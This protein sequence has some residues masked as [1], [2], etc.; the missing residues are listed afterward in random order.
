MPQSRQNRA[1]P[2][3]V[4][5]R[6]GPKHWLT[7]TRK[8]SILGAA[9]TAPAAIF[10]VLVIGYPLVYLFRLSL[11]KVTWL[12][13]EILLSW[14]G[15]TNYSQVLHDALFWAAFRHTLLI[16]VVS[17]SASL[18]LGLA[19]AI[20][21]DHISRGRIL[22]QTALL[23]PWVIA[24][25]LSSAM[26]KWLYNDQFGIINYVLTSLHLVKQPILWL[27]D[28]KIAI[29]SIILADFWQY[30]PFVMILLF[31]GLQ[32]IPQQLYEAA[33]I[34][35]ANSFQLLRHIS[36]PNLKPVLLF[37]ILIRTVFTLRI[38]DF[39]YT[40][41]RGGPAG[42]TQVLATLLYNSAFSFM[43]YGYAAAVAV[44]LL[45]ITIIASSG[46]LA[47]FRGDSA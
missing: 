45:I 13:G 23:L 46:I 6:L 32:A 40:L 34:D 33:R 20:A 5:Q 19:L 10:L 41:T 11:S 47:L 29:F 12:P 3:S 22:M 15:L 18:L 37:V 26:W 17:V 28:P 42:S 25:A 38:F 14:T 1:E 7:I 24:P 4:K 36:L 43:K 8:D 16:L 35:G 21:L 27:A 9:L 44:I 2:V 30:T 39:I 31:A